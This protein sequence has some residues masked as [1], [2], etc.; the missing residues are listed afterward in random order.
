MKAAQPKR[1]VRI[2][3]LFGAPTQARVAREL[4]V[5]LSIV[6]RWAR[7]RSIPNGYNLQR[8]A[9]IFGISAD[10]IDLEIEDGRRPRSAEST[11]VS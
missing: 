11:R 2:S 1:K 6:N 8:L 7:G 4:G 3:E 9:K 5:D 10:D